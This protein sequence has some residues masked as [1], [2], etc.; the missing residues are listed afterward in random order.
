MSNATLTIEPGTTL[1]FAPGAGLTVQQGGSLAA[2]GT[3]LFT[4]YSSI[5][6]TTRRASL[7]RP[8]D[9]GG[10]TLGSGAG[11]SSLE[12]CGNSVWRGPDA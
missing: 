12:F 3:A 10:V 2:N 6:P 7:P 9:W 5:R 4:H 8:G 1:L 11:G